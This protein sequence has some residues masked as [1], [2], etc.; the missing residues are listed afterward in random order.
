MEVG[1]ALVA[2]VRNCVYSFVSQFMI[3]PL[4]ALYF[5][6]PT[7]NGFGFWGG[8]APETICAGLLPGSQAS[9]WSLH[10]NECHVLLTQ[11]FDAFYVAIQTCFYVFFILKLVQCLTFHWL[12]VQPALGR[13][14]R[15]LS[16][17]NVSPTSWNDIPATHVTT[18]GA[19]NTHVAAAPIMFS[20]TQQTAPNTIY[21]TAQSTEW[22]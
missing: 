17:K 8:A 12:V 9:F 6:G 14:E 4:H 13:L 7:L 20:S 5:R 18:N 1:V 19:I 2:G 11:R 21:C 10:M 16:R 22:G 3:A 15:L